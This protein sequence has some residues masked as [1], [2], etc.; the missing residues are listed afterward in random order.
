MFSERIS[1]MVLSL[2]D[3][4]KLSRSPRTMV[5]FDISNTGETDAVGSA[6]YFDNGKPKKTEYRHFK[7]KG[8]KGQDDFKMMREIVGRYF[9][10]LKEDKL[11]PPDLVVVDGG[12]GQLSNAQEELLSLGF[13]DQSIISLAKRLE[14][15]YVPHSSDPI[16]LP[17]GSPGLILLKRIRDEAHRFAITYN[18]KVR[19]KRTITS[20]LDDIPG[21]GPA[22][23][24]L[25][26]TEFGSV[27]RIRQ[28]SVEEL[29]R[30]KG[31]NPKL[32]ESILQ[33]LS[34]AEG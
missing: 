27:E 6:V 20:A 23:R 7:I 24:Q 2:K 13:T 26:L 1:K 34:A 16:T 17:K 3:E 32:A 4:L 19:T 21:V 15:V 22:K 10:H 31:I 14:E 11:E 25:L 30:V 29:T 33:K 9:Y 12:K 8:V 28:M 18:R 5:C